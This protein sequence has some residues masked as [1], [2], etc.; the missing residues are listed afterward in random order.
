M[1]SHRAINL[2]ANLNPYYPGRV[3]ANFLIQKKKNSKKSVLELRK[4]TGD[5]SQ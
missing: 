4:Q 5:K 1:I 3:Q 2:Y